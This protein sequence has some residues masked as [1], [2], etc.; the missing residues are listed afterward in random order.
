LQ[1]LE[2]T[3]REEKSRLVRTMNET[4]SDQEELEELSRDLRVRF[5]A[6]I[7]ASEPTE[8]DLWKSL[9]A[10]TGGCKATPKAK[11]W[12]GMRTKTADRSGKT[13][14]WITSDPIVPNDAATR[15]GCCIAQVFHSREED[16]DWTKDNDSPTPGL[17]P[18]RKKR[19]LSNGDSDSSEIE[20]GA[21]N[22]LV[23]KAAKIAYMKKEEASSKTSKKGA[24]KEGEERKDEAT[25]EAPTVYASLGS[26]SIEVDPRRLFI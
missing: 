19:G 7:Q 13:N 11:L 6:K 5:K 16:E 2:N 17:H 14:R 21:L 25:P 12:F 4:G 1:E 18:R 22:S 26:S 3:E 8:D 24:G 15:P 23:G 9:A 10:K 20:N